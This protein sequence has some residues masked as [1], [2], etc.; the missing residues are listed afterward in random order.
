M[1]DVAMKVISGNCSASKKS[2]ERRCA[3][4]RSS[5]VFEHALHG[6]DG[7]VLDMELDAQWTGSTFQ[8]PVGT[9]IWVSLVESTA[10]MPLSFRGFAG[11]PA[12]LAKSLR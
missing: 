10:D 2:G 5:R 8:V 3:S 7:E 6:R 12:T 9:G 1:I 4:R 11:R